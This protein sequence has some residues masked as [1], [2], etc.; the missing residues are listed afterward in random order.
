M[1]NSVKKSRGR[2]KTVKKHEATQLGKEIYWQEGIH[3]YLLN[4]ICH[5]AKISKP[6]LSREF[7]SADGLMT[8]ALPHYRELVIVPMLSLR[9]LFFF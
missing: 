9:H 4:E 8:A 2:P 1:I 5:R 7:K 6:A 3:K